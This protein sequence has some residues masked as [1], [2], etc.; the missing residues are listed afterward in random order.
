LFLEF[1]NFFRKF[2]SNWQNEVSG[3]FVIISKFRWGQSATELLP[4]LL[5]AGDRPLLNVP[6][7]PQH[8]VACLA[9]H[10]Q[11]LAPRHCLACSYLDRSAALAF[12][13]PTTTD[14]LLIP[15]ARHRATARYFLKLI[16]QSRS[17]LPCASFEPARPALMCMCHPRAAVFLTHSQCAAELGRVM[18]SALRW[19]SPS[20][21]KCLRFT[22][23][24][25]RSS[26]HQLHYYRLLGPSPSSCCRG[27]CR[28]AAIVV[29]IL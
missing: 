27:G 17:P 15:L 11:L 18:D 3:S 4:Y 12:F 16:T 19:V 23:S 14:K 22:V 25:Y 29:A 13:F 26:L 28:R 20:A 5:T 10:K 6:S 24:F 8:T 7:P 2:V 21:K 9:A 1:F